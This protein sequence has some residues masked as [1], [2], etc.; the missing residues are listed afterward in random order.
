M[1]SVKS[2]EIESDREWQKNSPIRKRRYRVVLTDNNAVDHETLTAPVK[3]DAADDGTSTANKLL[4]SLKS[5]ELS[6]GD[7]ATQWHD[8]QADYDRRALGRAMTIADADE[9]Y[10]YLPLF[11]A[12]EAR[13]GANAN[14]RAAYLGVSTANY[15]LMADRFG[16]VEGIAFFL[17]N[18]KGQIW[19]EIPAEFE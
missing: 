6:K 2:V 10:S 4:E 5:S 8:S 7:Q 3:V 9:F 13:G 14:Q 15:N 17:D 11:K 12:M 1:A 19:D 18:A 16:D